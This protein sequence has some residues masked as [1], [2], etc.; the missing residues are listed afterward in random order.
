MLS[1][2]GD[3]VMVLLI[4][5]RPESESLSM[6]DIIKSSMHIF[7]STQISAPKMTCMNFRGKR[8]FFSLRPRV[9]ST[10]F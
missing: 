9:K 10:P 5:F 3:V 1:F 4:A 8:R 6:H 2:V 7:N